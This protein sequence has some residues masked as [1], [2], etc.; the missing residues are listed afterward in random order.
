MGNTETKPIIKEI[1]G[2]AIPIYRSPSYR[3]EYNLI[4]SFIDKSIPTLD[5]TSITRYLGMERMV[6]LPKYTDLRP[7]LPPVLRCSQGMHS[8]GVVVSLSHYQFLHQNLRVFPS[9]R[10]FIYYNMNF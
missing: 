2:S 10:S 7:D 4:P 6:D 5:E 3:L 1:S 9:S 8:L